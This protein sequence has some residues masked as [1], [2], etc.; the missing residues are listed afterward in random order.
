MLGICPIAPPLGW[1]RQKPPP[2]VLPDRSHTLAHG[3]R[4][5]VP[6]NEAAGALVNDAAGGRAG[7]IINAEA[8]DWRTRRG[9]L[10]LD[11]TDDYIRFPPLGVYKPTKPLSTVTRLVLPVSPPANRYLWT[12]NSSAGTFAIVNCTIGSGRAF[13]FGWSGDSSIYRA[14]TNAIPLNTPSTVATTYDGSS[15]YTGIR[16]F[17]NGQECP[18]TYTPTGSNLYAAVGALALGGRADGYSPL[19]C[20]YEWFGLWDRVLSSDEIRRLHHEGPWQMFEAE[21]LSACGPDVLGPYLTSAGDVALT[22][23]AAGQPFVAGA[24]CGE[25]FLA[26]ANVGCTHA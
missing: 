3:L 2:G 10:T 26:G 13:S 16:L 14:S 5:F 11:G 24:A 17:L 15:L 8:P 25:H 18:Y 7:K 4:F 20:I 22:G 12:L 9:W 23:A 1:G 21:L 6:L 19:N